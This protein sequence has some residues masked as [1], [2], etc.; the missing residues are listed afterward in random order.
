MKIVARYSHKGGEEYIRKNHPKEYKEVEEVIESVK[1][2]ELKTKISEE[3]TMMGKALYSP[4]ELNN[5][6]QEELE[7]KGWKLKEKVILSVD[8]PE[9]G[10]R[11]EGPRE[12]DAIKNGLGLEIQFGKYAFMVYNILA[13]MTIFANRGIIDSGIEIVPMLS[14]AREMSTG[15]SYFE[16][17]KADL[18]HR[19][20][21]EIDIPVVIL[22]IDDEERVKNLG[23][24]T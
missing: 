13:K 17:V 2:S 14:M 16:Q 11:H 1:A 5:E 19:G 22:G 23:V 3:K 4:I 10:E 8:I 18:V 9:T 6:F 20:E 7:K 21:S 12:I 24:I 15:V